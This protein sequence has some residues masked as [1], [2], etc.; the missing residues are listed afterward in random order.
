MKSTGS[1]N[2]DLVAASEAGRALDRTVLHADHQTAGRGRLDRRWEA[3]P[4]TN[5]LASLL[6][7]EAADPPSLI[8]RAVAVASL[9]AVEAI[10]GRDLSG[11]LG[12]KWPNDLLLDDRKLSGVLA[13]R[14]SSGSIVV[15]IGLNV[16]WSPAGGASLSADLGVAASPVIVLER[17]LERLDER[18]RVGDVDQRYRERLSTLG[19]RV[20]VDL[21]GGDSVTG[22]ATDLDHQGRLVLDADGSDGEEG[23]MTLDVG[24]IVH[25]RPLG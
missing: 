22:T 10:V 12:L 21:P 8:P 4:A 25:L 11:R 17:L 19:A 9:E 24:D 15:G 1:T 3:P 14:T 20:R 16:G 5:L 23:I 18:L 2:A 13:Q 7:A 6:F